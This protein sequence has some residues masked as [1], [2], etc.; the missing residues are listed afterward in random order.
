M[1][2]TPSTILS[3]KLSGWLKSAIA[4]S[5]L[6]I[7][8]ACRQAIAPVTQAPGSSNAPPVAPSPQAA[9][10][11]PDIGFASRRKWQEHFE[12]HGRE[13]GNV[14]ADEYLRQGQTLRDCAAGGDVLESVRRD[15]VV[16]RFDKQSGTF[17]AFDSDL[18]IRTCFKPND[19]VNYFW[20]Q[21]KR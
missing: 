18:T 9:I 8:A 19:G 2:L 10:K 21:S 11:H 7:L 13:F 4:L 17:L 1:G 3:G 5:A 12:K 20:R 14:T 16:T 15:G 6:L